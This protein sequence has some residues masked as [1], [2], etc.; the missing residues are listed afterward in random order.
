M[1]N[2]TVLMVIGKDASKDVLARQ[3]ETLRAMPARAAVLVVAEVPN[4]PYYAVG[5]PPYGSILLTGRR[6]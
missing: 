1:I 4:F 3:F 5:I 6:R 2:N